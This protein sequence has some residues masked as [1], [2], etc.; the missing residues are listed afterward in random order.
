LPS[1]TPLEYISL[2]RKGAIKSK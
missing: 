1:A 2:C